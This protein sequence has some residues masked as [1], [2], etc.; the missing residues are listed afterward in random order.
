[1]PEYPHNAKLL[2]PIEKDYAVWRL[3]QE[4]GAGEANEDSTTL[5]GFKQALLD[6]KIW[7]MVFC[8]MMAQ[9]MASTN[10]FFPSIVQVSSNY[11]DA[12]LV[13]NTRYRRSDTTRSCLSCS[14]HHHF[15]LLLSCFGASHGSA[16]ARTSSTGSSSGAWL[17]QFQRISLRW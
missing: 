2:K 15:S 12:A 16:I 4:A 9:A 11:R 6:P 14:L 7:A 3:E 10:N 17:A 1:M 13:P 5:G 8:M